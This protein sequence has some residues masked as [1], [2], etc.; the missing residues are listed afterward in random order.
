MRASILL[1]LLLVFFPLFCYPAGL[2]E[3]ADYEGR[4]YSLE[5]YYYD[6]ETVYRSAQQIPEHSLNQIG[7]EG[8]RLISGG[9]TEVRYI[10]NSFYIFN[11]NDDGLI[12]QILGGASYN[13]EKI[14]NEAREQHYSISGR[15]PP[16]DFNPR[17]RAA[18]MFDNILYTY[19]G[20]YW[21]DANNEYVLVDVSSG[22]PSVYILESEN[23]RNYSITALSD[24]NTWIMLL[25]STMN[26]VIDA[27]RAYIIRYS[28][29][30]LQFAA[31]NHSLLFERTVS[32]RDCVISG[33]NGG[34][35]VFVD[36]ETVAAYD[37]S[38]GAVR[39][40][41]KKVENVRFDMLMM[42]RSYLYEDEEG[43]RFV[44]ESKSGKAYPAP[45]ENF[46]D[47]GHFAKGY[48]YEEENRRYGVV[49]LFE[50]GVLKRKLILYGDAIRAASSLVIIGDKIYI[51]GYLLAF[52]LD[53]NTGQ[54]LSA[55][56]A[57]Y[58][59]RTKIDVHIFPFA[60]SDIVYT[61]TI[62]YGR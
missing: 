6:N 21:N 30:V 2:R 32:W 23:L 38:T 52:T 54:V 20:V 14:V 10:P 39:H 15:E 25:D 57:R 34:E 43:R 36:G 45:E 40:M 58:S 46:Y 33:W 17:W 4:G 5:F 48:S 62:D 18:R 19:N 61:H 7:P 37:F 49:C 56:N 26:F 8:T 28:G 53:L 11:D 59:N 13:L 1:A 24:P 44:V 29:E 22:I 47:F 27:D 9:Q 3:S 60:E 51:S 55:F 41:G 12:L 16:D 50:D 42:R 35:R 31:G